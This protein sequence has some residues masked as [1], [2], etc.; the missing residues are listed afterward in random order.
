MVLI[1]I[2]A[3]LLLGVAVGLG[4]WALVEPRARRHEN[5]AGIDA[6]GYS[7]AAQGGVKP[8]RKPIVSIDEVATSLGDF[9]ARRIVNFRESD[10]QRELISAGFYR[11]G[12]RRFLGYRALAAIILPILVVWLLSLNGASPGMIVLCAVAAFALGWV[13]PNF[14]VHRKAAH[15]LMVIDEGLPALIDLLVVT[16]EAGVAFSGALKMAAER[17][18]GPLGDEIR[19]TVQEQALGL[20]M[21]EAL[22]NFLRR[23]NTPNV[24][25]FV[26]AMVQ[27][28]RLGVSIGTI[29]RNQAIEMRARQRAMVTER[30]Q[31]API[32]ILFPL[33]FLIFPA[34]FLIILGPA[35]FQISK[36]LK[37]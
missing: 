14:Y 34:M 31:K 10:T 21:L 20:S 18:T 30:A 16:L 37:G 8:P 2:L 5:L 23:C 17:L 4:V 3:V 9:V 36:S 24:R 19:L 25:S 35:M 33:V 13:G 12:A 27:G 15:R 6:Y 29:L 28:D 26:R 1:L 32:K 11:I 22:E 7:S